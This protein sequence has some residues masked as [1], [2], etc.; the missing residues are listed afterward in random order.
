MHSCDEELPSSAVDFLLLAQMAATQA[1]ATRHER[2][3][4]VLRRMAKTYLRRAKDLGWEHSRELA[5][6]SDQGTAVA[7]IG[8][9]LRVAG[10]V[11]AEN[12]PHLGQ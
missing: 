3:A 8:P 7:T 2:T 1:R 11:V 10:P 4:R 9:H 12:P 6:A 5:T